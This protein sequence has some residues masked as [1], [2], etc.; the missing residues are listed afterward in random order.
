M[1]KFKFS[2]IQL[3][4]SILPSTGGTANRKI[5]TLGFI[6]LM[7]SISFFVHLIVSSTFH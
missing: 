4:L 5:V 3:F 7:L 2:I 1:N 6:N